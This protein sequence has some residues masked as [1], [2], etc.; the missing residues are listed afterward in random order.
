MTATRTVD[1]AQLPVAGTWK[2][3]PSH[4][5][6]E[7]V[8]RHLMVTKVRGGF[9]AVDGALVVGEDPSTS[10]VQVT[11]PTA[12]ISTGAADRD[13]H[14]KG[15]DFLDV[16]QFPTMTFTSTAVEGS[17]EKWRVEGD[18][19][20]RGVTKPVTLDV[21]FGGVSPDPWGGQRAG[22]SASTEI[23]REDWGLTW[24]VAL[25]TGGMLVSKNIRIE[26]EAQAVLS[27]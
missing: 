18:L 21:E 19:T 2:I 9:S 16:E 3:D 25:E 17:G 27:A 4:T 12:T 5:T 20:I 14:V 22:F 11:I 13:G 24:N 26:I 10:S 8:A 6:V 7:F 1:G 15:A 23:N